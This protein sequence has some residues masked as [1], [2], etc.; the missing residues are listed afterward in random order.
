MV[1]VILR[2]WIKKTVDTTSHA[3]IVAIAVFVNIG[4][5]FIE[6]LVTIDFEMLSTSYIISELFLLGVHLV[7]NENQRL[8]ELVRQKEESKPSEPP[9][10][11]APPL[12][13][14]H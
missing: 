5:W 7:M 10:E 2:A 1:T 3:V 9:V 4:V 14:F 8:K 12:P 11:K 13:R 6:Q